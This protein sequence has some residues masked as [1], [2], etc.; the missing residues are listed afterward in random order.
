M[1]YVEDLLQQ[2]DAR[3]IRTEVQ[4]FEVSA[5][6]AG[7]RLDNYVRA[8]L[9]G[10][11]RSRSIISGYN[12]TGKLKSNLRSNQSIRAM[13]RSS[14]TVGSDASNKYVDSPITADIHSGGVAI[15]GFADGAEHLSRLSGLQ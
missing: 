6:E 14:S 9:A 15:F 13:T 2:P 1:P 10:V 12:S 7:Q 11:P 4:H 8:R 3:P 5:E